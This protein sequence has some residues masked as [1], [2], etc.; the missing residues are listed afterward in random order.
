VLLSFGRLTSAEARGRSERIVGDSYCS[1]VETQQFPDIVW[2][3]LFPCASRPE[4]I[5]ERD[6]AASTLTTSID[7]SDIADSR[8]K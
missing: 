3:L 2:S 1:G 4:H 7:T 8:F 6:R 5:S